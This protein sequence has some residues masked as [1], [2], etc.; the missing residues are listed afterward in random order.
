MSVTKRIST[1]NYNIL[2][3]Q[4]AANTVITTHTLQIFGNLFVQGNTTT[5]NVANISTADP[6]ITLNSNVSSPFLGNSGIEVNRGTG[7][8]TPALF[9]N[10]TAGAWQIVSNIADPTSY[11]NIA[12]ILSG[13]GTVDSGTAGRIAY[14]ASSGTTV[15][16]TAS[17]LTWDNTNSILQVTGNLRATTIR[18]N[19][20]LALVSGSD[21]PSAVTGNLV[22]TGNTTGGS[23]GGTGIYFNNGTES[24]EL[25]SKTKA[26]VYS[27]IFS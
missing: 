10:E 3:A 8:A 2:T 9:W 19:S 26:V 1:G 25:I 6:T 14:Y 13:S 5:I 22:I 18:A 12:T 11:S 16:N 24:G 7:Y 4:S 20:T 17:T 27:I 21:S 23:A 15:S